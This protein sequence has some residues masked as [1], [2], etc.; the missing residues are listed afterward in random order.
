MDQAKDMR[1]RKV[2]D[3]HKDF[4]LSNWINSSVIVYQNMRGAQ[5]MGIL[6]KISSSFL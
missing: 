2:K 4:G 5:S 1:K 3:I 6:D